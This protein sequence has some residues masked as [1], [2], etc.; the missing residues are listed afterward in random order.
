MIAVLVLVIAGACWGTV[1]DHHGADRVVDWLKARRQ[2][3]NSRHYP[4]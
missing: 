1:F 3:R 2:R 4:V